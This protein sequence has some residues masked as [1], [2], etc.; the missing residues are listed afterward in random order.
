MVRPRGG[1]FARDIGKWGNVRGLAA[2]TIGKAQRIL[3]NW[4]DF[5]IRREV[6]RYT[7]GSRR[8]YQ[9]ESIHDFKAFEKEMI[10]KGLTPGS[11]SSRLSYIV[12]YYEYAA[13]EYPDDDFYTNLIPKLKAHKR[14]KVRG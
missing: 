4:E 3:S 14:P 1:T 13:N 5:L 8:A 10:K 9:A 11:I 2:S 7:P 12:M 6:K